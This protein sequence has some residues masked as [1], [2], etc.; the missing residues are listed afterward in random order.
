[1]KGLKISGIGWWKVGMI[2]EGGSP[3]VF[4]REPTARVKS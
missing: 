2:G 4:Y 1:M 3:R